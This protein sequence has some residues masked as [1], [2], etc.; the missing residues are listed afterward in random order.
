MMMLEIYALVATALLV[1][2]LWL[3]W[4]KNKEC[5][6][7]RVIAESAERKVKRQDAIIR[8]LSVADP[9]EAKVIEGELA[10]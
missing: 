8:R 1:L 2:W 10:D 4:I 5:E 3:Y 7:W 9:L 6:C